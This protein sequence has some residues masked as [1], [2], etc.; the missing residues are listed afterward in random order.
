MGRTARGV[1]RPVEPQHAAAADANGTSPVGRGSKWYSGALHLHTTHSDG[2]EPPAA[3]S[4]RARA[5]GLDFIA[6]TDHNNTIHAREP[7]PPLPLH[8]VG[9]EVTTPAGHANVWGLPPGGWIDFR[10]SPAEHGAAAAVE[11]LAAEA[12]SAGG[13]FAINHPFDVCSGCSWEQI[14]PEALDAIEVW[15]GERGPQ[16]Q[17]IAQWDRLLQSGRRVTAIGASDWHRVP[18]PIEAPAVRVHA[19][20]LST[21]AILD[22]IRRGRVVIVRNPGIAAPSIVARCGDTTAGLG[23][24]LTCR[25]GERVVVT[26]SGTGPAGERADLIVNGTA[27]DSK[28]IADEAVLVTQAVDGYLRVN[29]YTREAGLTAIANPIHVATR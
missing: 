24:T 13:Q 11:R 16:D 14:V 18:A 21:P 3:V 27:R 22:G 28:P 29:M 25:R 8:I 6:I 2:A 1:D 4:E 10:V 5:A 9:E 15:N 23:D 7:M 12:R 19:A 26:T 17:A 20:E